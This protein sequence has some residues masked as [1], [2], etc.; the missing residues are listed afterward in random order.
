MK[1]KIKL[2]N[3]SICYGRGIMDC[4]CYTLLGGNRPYCKYYHIGLELGFDDFYSKKT[5]AYIP[6]PRRCIKE[7]GE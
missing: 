5:Y 7:N 4:P 1:L 2:D 6:R 3:P